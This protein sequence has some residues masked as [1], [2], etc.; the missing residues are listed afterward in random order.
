MTDQGF[1]NVLNDDGSVTPVKAGD[2]ALAGLN[3]YER[4]NQRY[5]TKPGSAVDNRYKGDHDAKLVMT[6]G[7]VPVAP[8]D[9][10]AADSR[11]TASQAATATSTKAPKTADK[12][13]VNSLTY[14]G[15]TA[16]GQAI[17]TAPSSGTSNSALSAG[18]N[19]GAANPF[20]NADQANAAIGTA[21]GPIRY[22]A[23]PVKNPLRAEPGEPGSVSQA[24]RDS[25]AVL[26]KSLYQLSRPELK[27]LQQK[28][29]GAGY[30]KVGKADIS[31]LMNTATRDA[32]TDLLQDVAE[33]QAN[34]G[35][36]S[37]L[38][39][40]EYLDQLISSGA[41]A[42][43]RT[44]TSSSSRTSITSTTDARATATDAFKKAL[45]R[46][47]SEKQM[48]AFTSALQAYESAH[49][50]TS[51]T[52][53][54]S[55]TGATVSTTETDNQGIDATAAAQN[56]VHSGALGTEA[57]TYSVATDYY[58]AALN[59]LGLGGT[60]GPS[61]PHVTMAERSGPQ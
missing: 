61:T 11:V 27:K 54:D 59:S 24:D 3:I 21:F 20:D 55:S 32:Y 36:P 35:G 12:P 46:A 43:A 39:P 48:Q 10:K 14:S 33:G 2:P 7:G 17:Y 1:V 19:G 13:D 4:A 51:S 28:L 34:P 31:G 5:A 44:T 23:G 50:S 16:N 58:A 52:V 49:P 56:Y 9:V 25:G 57:N 38:T 15:T 29:Y 22:R 6:V 26:L 37:D 60:G 41:G 8:A 18:L 53:S 47:P 45:G 30:T 42:K 40:D